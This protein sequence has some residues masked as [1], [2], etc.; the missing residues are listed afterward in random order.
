[1]I[2]KPSN[3]SFT[4]SII[5]VYD[6]LIIQQFF[7]LSEYPCQ[8]TPNSVC[9]IYIIYIPFSSIRESLATMSSVHVAVPRSRSNRQFSVLNCQYDIGTS[10]GATWRNRQLSL[11]LHFTVYHQWVFP[12]YLYLYQCYLLYLYIICIYDKH[13]FTRLSKRE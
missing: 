11:F 13:T 2:E 5:I 12:L 3:V 9:V 1:M 10:R 7:L 6:L 8:V 4:F